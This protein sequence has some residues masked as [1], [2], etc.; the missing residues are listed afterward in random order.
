M[1]TD[2]DEI[3]QIIDAYNDVIR[4]IDAQAHDPA[5]NRAYGGIV[6]AGKGKL[7]ESITKQ[8]VSLAWKKLEQSESD[9]RIEHVIKRIPLN[10][11]YIERIKDPEIKR[12]LQEHLPS[13]QYPLGIDWTISI[14]IED[15]GG[16]QPIIGSEC[17]TYTENAM[18][19]RV[20]VDCSLLKEVYPSMKFVLVQLES[21]LGGDFS[22]LNPITYGSPS[23]HTLFS[24]FNIDLNIITLLKGERKVDRP[25]HKAEFFKPLERTNLERAINQISKVL[26]SYI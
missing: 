14:N 23:T 7:H 10:P 5:T 12:Y 2:V 8:I 13:L 15:L 19:K 11:G 26:E 25:I 4:G 16:F 20:L 3:Q 18:L 22:E 17:K 1:P 21:Q 9:I 24:Y 6:R